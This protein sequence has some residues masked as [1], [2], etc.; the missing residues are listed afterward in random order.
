MDTRTRTLDQLRSAY[1]WGQV[2][3]ARKALGEG[4][5]DYRSLI[6]K[7][8]ALI[9]NN[10]LG[11]ALAFLASDAGMK[12]GRVDS[13]KIPGLVFHHLADWL[14]HREGGYAGP[15]AGQPAGGLSALQG[16]TSRQYLRA[17]LEAL[18]ILSYLKLFAD[19]LKDGSATP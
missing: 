11:Q 16:G 8:P 15:Y 5:K 7:L 17:R 2:E 6:K 13:A 12:G 3:A 9:A 19:A 14:H 1:A 10:G 4:F 18:A